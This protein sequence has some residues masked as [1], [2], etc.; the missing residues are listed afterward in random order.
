MKKS[1]ILFA[2]SL[3]ALAGCSRNQEID[4]PDANLSLF[5]RTESPA[6]S[7]TVVESGVHVFWEPGD[8]I[9]VFSQ[10]TSSRFTTDI[11]EPSATAVFTGNLDGYSSGSE[12]WAIYPYSEVASFVNDTLTT[13]IPYA[14]QARAGSFAQRQNV[15]IAK[16]TSKNLSFYNVLGG[17][18]F[19]VENE[20]ISAV[21]M[22]S[23]GNE[24]LTGK[25]SITFDG[26]AP[27]LSVS[28]E[29]SDVV[30]LTAK[31]GE[32]L[33][34]GEWYYISTIP[35]EISKGFRFRFIKGKSSGVSSIEKAVTVRRGVFG[36]IE[37]ADNGVTFHSEEEMKEPSQQIEDII[38]S[39][40]TDETNADVLLASRVDEIKSNPAVKDVIVGEAATT[41]LFKNG[42]T[43]IYPY[44]YPSA[45]DENPESSTSSYSSSPRPKTR[46][47][48]LNQGY[49]DADIVVFNLFSEQ[50]GRSRQ[51]E[52]MENIAYV[53]QNGFHQRSVCY[54][55]LEDFTVE[56]VNK[57]IANNSI[58]FFSTLGSDD[59]R[60]ICTGERYKVGKP[61]QD[62]D[63]A[64]Y[65]HFYTTVSFQDKV[66]GHKRYAYS[67]EKLVKNY[68]GPLMYFASCNSMKSPDLYDK[69]TGRCKYSNHVLGWNGINKCG[70]AF[71]LIIADYMAN[72]GKDFS[73]FAKDFSEEHLPLG[74]IKDPLEKGTKMVALTDYAWSS[75]SYTGWS[76]VV[77]RFPMQIVTP[78]FGTCIKK[79]SNYTVKLYYHNDD[80]TSIVTDGKN[81]TYEKGNKYFLGFDN[82]GG[83][84]R[85]SE[86]LHVNKDSWVNYT[87]KNFSAGVWKI[88][89]NQ[90]DSYGSAY[91]VGQTYLIM[92]KGYKE[93]DG[94]TEEIMPDPK[95]ETLRADVESNGVF[96]A[97]AVIN[98]TLDGLETGFRYYKFSTQDEHSTMTGQD[99]LS[100]IIN[101]GTSIPS[102]AEYKGYFGVLLSDIDNS[103]KYEVVA[104]AKDE[105]GLISY[106]DIYRFGFDISDGEYA[107]PEAID[108]GLPS[109]LLWASFNL[110]ATK[111]EE[112]GGYFAWGETEPYYESLNPPS[113]KP[114]KQDGYEWP[115]YKWCMGDYSSLTKYCTTP[116]YGYN[117]FTDGKTILDPEDDAANVNLGD[118][119]R[120][121][122]KIELEE[123]I[124][125]CSSQKTVKN[126]TNGYILTGPNGNSIFFPIADFIESV[127]GVSSDFS[128]GKYCS[129][130]PSKDSYQT[131]GLFFSSYGNYSDMEDRCIGWSVRPVFGDPKVDTEI[132][133]PE[134]VDLGLSVKWASFNLGATK[135]EEFGDFYAWGE[136]EPYYKP[137]QALVKDP[138]WKLGKESGYDTPSYQWSL[139][140]ANTLT[141]YCVD[142]AYGANGFIDG[143]I[144]LDPDDDAAHVKLGGYWRMPTEAEQNELQARC[145][146]TWV[147][148]GN[149]NGYKVTG[150]NGNSIFLPAAGYRMMDWFTN[151]NSN[152]YYWSSSLYTGDSQAACAVEFHSTNFYWTGCPR[153]TGYSIR[154]VYDDSP[155]DPE[156]VDM[157][158]SV[159]WA[160][161]N[162]GADSFYDS[163]DFYAWGEIEQK[164]EYSWETYC[165]S[166]GNESSLTKYYY[167]DGKTILDS[168]DDVV[169]QRLGGK[170]RM[171][172]EAE[173]RELVDNCWWTQE[174]FD[175]IKGMNACSKINGSD[176]FFPFSGRKEGT[177]LQKAGSVGY[178]WTSSLYPFES[179]ACIGTTS[180]DIGYLERYFGL[181]IRPVC[182]K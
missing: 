132:K 83:I 116:E 12:L 175:G 60:Y 149:V 104:Y 97:G 55:G 117:G 66:D 85:T 159:K 28:S 170:W 46:A 102:S 61:G 87:Q 148:K 140:S 10:N 67:V 127:Y 64:K 119:W 106:G 58:I 153:E 120:L 156:Y 114:G 71:A 144:A 45:F 26:A 172:T 56:N 95:V 110:G 151:N 108:L 15:S 82:M 99:S 77:S 70:Q 52:L 1:F 78:A 128:I 121:P 5:A 80:P 139:G 154:P 7:R 179:S 76:E 19:T 181:P 150:P 98:R 129:S 16:T 24:P 4:V 138:D 126:G 131:Y 93:N 182:D 91:I 37:H 94:E 160:T 69:D 22:E 122:T 48:D 163:G 105:T 147:T 54:C 42:E 133:T 74:T 11:E 141:K 125:Y 30:I 166:N 20:G 17:V 135:P 75:G 103:G 59:G 96:L 33:I 90:E 143:D 57:A 29:A 14:Q 31:E 124:L 130:S 38:S 164:K 84:I 165:W 113:W 109:G 43:L 107:V 86:Y 158:L 73:A 178:Y 40:V 100:L 3:L 49:F 176:L 21:V 9:M 89:L 13:M 146:W 111:P 134:I 118:K 174:E 142:P 88:S 32:T 53:F 101:R 177:V 168:K 8:E 39:C 180:P 27:S 162:L 145:S 112:Y 155:K 44:N 34:P 167:G 41:V 65:T 6:E 157:G 18:R 36:S 115:S 51:N 62:L 137:G 81:Y 63:G 72:G 68:N 2:A 161:Y 79:T 50:S 47:S 136:T 171:P 25:V 23:I 169:F 152:G 92:H 173:W 35:G 123:L